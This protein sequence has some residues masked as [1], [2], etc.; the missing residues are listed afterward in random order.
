MDAPRKHDD[1]GRKSFDF[2]YDFR[3]TLKVHIKLDW[4]RNGNSK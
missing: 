2:F 3:N 4:I 1:A